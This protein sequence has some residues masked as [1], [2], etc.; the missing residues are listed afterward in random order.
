MEG[1]AVHPFAQLPTPVVPAGAPVP[2]FY[3]G[4]G[5]GA[6]AFGGVGLPDPSAYATYGASLDPYA[7]AIP[8]YPVYPGTAPSGDCGCGA[9]AAPRLPYALPLR[10][11]PQAT[12]ALASLSGVTPEAAPEPADRDTPA[13]AA[14]PKKAKRP[15]KRKAR[16]S[17]ASDALRS[18]LRRAGAKKRPSR[19]KSQ[20]W[21]NG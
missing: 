19:R 5:Y 9:S 17:S 4:F 10:S 14:A 16:V 8:A 12:D 18:F 3:P 21:V 2:T 6:P 20:P 7:P 1:E 11:A 13:P 15:A